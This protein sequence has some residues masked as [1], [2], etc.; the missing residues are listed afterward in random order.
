VDVVLALR[1]INQIEDMQNA[2][3]TPTQSVLQENN[4]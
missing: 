4:Y 2:I 3:F 1:R